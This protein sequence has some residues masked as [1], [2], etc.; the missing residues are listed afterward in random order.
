MAKVEFTGF[1]KPRKRY[2]WP[3]QTFGTAML[4]RWD[5]DDRGW[6][7]QGYIVLPYPRIGN[8][9]AETIEEGQCVRHSRC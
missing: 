4:R 3:W 7:L 1:T 8:K 2:E 6:T 5:D 9:F